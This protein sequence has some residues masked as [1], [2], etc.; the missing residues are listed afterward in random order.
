MLI[1]KSSCN[2]VCFLKY[3]LL[4]VVRKRNYMSRSFHLNTSHVLII[5][6]PNKFSSY[7]F[8]INVQITLGFRGLL[9]QTLF[10]MKVYVGAVCWP[11][12][13]DAAWC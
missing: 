11:A 3:G 10:S 9:Y 7:K 12:I 6:N 5:N 1:N 4:Q 2:K 8:L 13:R